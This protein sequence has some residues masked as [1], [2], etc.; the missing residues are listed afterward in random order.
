MAERYDFITIDGQQYNISV[1]IGIKETAD[2]LDKYANRT[3]DGDLQRE[4]IGVYFNYSDIKFEPQTDNNYD[5]FERLWN[6][7]TEAEEF[8]TVKIANLEFRAYFNNVSR[9]IYDFR[10]NKAYR[11]D[12]TVN[13]TAKK[14]ARS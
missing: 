5:E 14:P 10:N 7:L 13:F 9:V 11:K 4:L 2:F 1:F 12:M 8:H 3:D 6:K